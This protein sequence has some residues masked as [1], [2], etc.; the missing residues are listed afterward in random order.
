[1]EIPTR[2]GR[3]D[4]QTFR[5]SDVSGFP[6]LFSKP[7]RTNTYETCPIIS[8]LTPFRINTFEKQGRG[9]PVI[10]NQI[11]DEEICPEEHRDE[12]TE[13]VEDL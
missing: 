6:P 1:V 12:R 11:S 8:A 3:S 7:F 2:S 4:V 13:V 10:V 5:R 9:Y